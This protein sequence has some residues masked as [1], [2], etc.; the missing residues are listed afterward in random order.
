MKKTFFCIPIQSQTT[1]ELQQKMK[2]VNAKAN[3]IEVWLDHFDQEL[4]PKE[5]FAITKK[6]LLLV[7]KP[8]KEGGRFQRSESQRW[9][10]L[11][12]YLPYSP[13]YIDM[14][15]ETKPQI[16]KE[17]RLLKK[18][19]TK[20]ILSYHHFSQT[21]SLTFLKKIV[22]KGFKHG[23][24]IVK[25][26]TFA[27]KTEDNLVI[28]NLLLQTK[29]PL[30]AHCMGQKGIISRLL[31]PRFGSG[32]VYVALDQKSKTA[33]GQLTKEEYQ[34]LKHNSLRYENRNR[35]TP[36]RRQINTF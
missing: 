32:I 23:A 22:T 35:R 29:Q 30:I 16:L 4:N 9:D 18:K 10:I 8:K 19:K 31:A 2:L 15:I 5:L 34:N 6:P 36:K 14:S 20:L 3:I 13:A 17:F 7:N 24:D 21:P 12:Q 1:K 11:K 25:I 33:P 26:A 27:Q 28:F